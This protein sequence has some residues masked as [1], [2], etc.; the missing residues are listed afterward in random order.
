MYD[1]V[2]TPLSVYLKTLWSRLF[3][4]PA[5]VQER[6]LPLQDSFEYS[7]LLLTG[8]HFGYC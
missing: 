5:Q 8:K 4:E 1:E 6:P 2:T 3:G 7:I